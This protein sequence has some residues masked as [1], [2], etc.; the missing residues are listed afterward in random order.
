[1]N[2]SSKL[3]VPG[4]TVEIKITTLTENT[5]GYKTLGEWGLSMLIEADGRR[6]L[7]DAG[8]TI[9]AVY[10]AKILGVDLSIIDTIVL[11]HGHYDHTG[12]LKDILKI[13]GGVNIIA[14]PDIWNSK[15]SSRDENK[16]E[17]IGNPHTREK[18]EQ[19]GAEFTLSREP[20]HITD[21]IMTT[22]EIPALNDYETIDDYLLV[23]DGEEFIHEE[24]ADDLALIINAEF[25]TVVILGCAHRG[26][27]NTLQHARKLTGKNK[28][29][30]AVG[31]T[32]LI[33]ASDER[34]YRT[35]AD[36]EDMGIERLGV[37]HCTGFH[38]SSLLATHFQDRFFLNNAGTMVTLP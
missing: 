38:A 30:A 6:I 2:I 37:S 1:V 19:M 16:K 33:H 31:G 18:L 36:L 14:H 5:A 21:T 17:Y 28:I 24:M 26:I 4:N 32:H 15:Y 11:S 9:T 35:I 7:M 3:Q 22:G 25:G 8:N 20:V 10:N 12:G 34:I 23:K 29:Y 27:I 13:K